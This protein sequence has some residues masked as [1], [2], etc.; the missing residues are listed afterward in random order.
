[1]P[2]PQ[3]SA[4]DAVAV[5][6]LSRAE[7][8]QALSASCRDPEALAFF[9]R[10]VARRYEER[11]QDGVEPLPREWIAAGPAD[12]SVAGIAALPELAASPA[13]RRYRQRRAR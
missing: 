1:M 8:G 7:L 6:L 4:G 2:P 9:L 11:I 5:R 10:E 12:R 3:E 13:R